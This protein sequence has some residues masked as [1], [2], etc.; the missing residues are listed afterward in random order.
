MVFAGKKGEKRRRKDAVFW[1]ADLGSFGD[2]AVWWWTMA[3][4]RERGTPEGQ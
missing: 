4:P 2:F 3:K 1:G